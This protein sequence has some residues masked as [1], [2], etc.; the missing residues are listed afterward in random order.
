MIETKKEQY[1]Y[2]DYEKLPEGAPYQLIGGDLVKSPSPTV[3][4]QE[5][6]AVLFR[7]F[8]PLQDKGKGK[9]L[10]APLDVYLSETETYQPDLLFIKSDNL[11]IIGKKK[12]EGAPDLIMEV[13]SPSTGYYDLRHKKDVY[14][15]KGVREYWIVDPMERSVEIHVN[16]EGKLEREMMVHEKGKVRSLLFPEVSITLVEIFGL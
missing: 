5:I 10:F 16:T 11:S 7:K 14:G 8:L 9:V 2:K 4:H 3:L 6:I 15:A 1:T 13:L 12:I